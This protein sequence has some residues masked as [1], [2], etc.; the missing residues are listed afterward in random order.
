MTIVRPSD[1]ILAIEES[2][3]YID[4]GSFEVAE[5]RQFKGELLSNRHGSNRG[6]VL[7]ADGHCDFVDRGVFT[8]AATEPGTSVQMGTSEYAQIPYMMNPH[9]K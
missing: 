2:S 5:L 8:R 9:A 3:A 7:Y 6:N 4:K 1:K